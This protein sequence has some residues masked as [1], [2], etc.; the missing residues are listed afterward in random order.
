MATG[1][2]FDMEKEFAGLDFPSVRL[3]DRFIQTMGTLCK[4]PDKSIWEAGENRAE[5]SD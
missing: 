3:E 1:K 4:Q 5:A 2:S